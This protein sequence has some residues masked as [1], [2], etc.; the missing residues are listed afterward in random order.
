M[1][2]TLYMKKNTSELVDK[3]FQHARRKS[4]SDEAIADK[5]GVAFF[6]VYRWKRGTNFPITRTITDRIKKVIEE[7]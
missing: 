5:I 2:Y 4:L 3:L 7:N 6:T 1:C